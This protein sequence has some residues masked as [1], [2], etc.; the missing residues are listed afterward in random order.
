MGL[1]HMVN[2]RRPNT[3]P[4]ADIG[5]A[6]IKNLKAL[7]PNYNGKA[8]ADLA[9][10]VIDDVWT[11]IGYSNL[12]GVTGVGWAIDVWLDGMVILPPGSMYNIATVASTT[13]VN[14]RTGFTWAELLL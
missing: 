7:V 1:A 12:N 13:T 2:A 10:T 4:T 9:A 3:K 14:T 8:I 6:S 11:P 5:P